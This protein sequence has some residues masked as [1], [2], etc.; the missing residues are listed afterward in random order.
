MEKS[1]L[2]ILLKIYNQKGEFLDR[3]LGRKISDE[4]KKRGVK[5]ISR[6]TRERVLTKHKENTEKLLSN[7]A[8]K[9]QD[10]T[11]QV[12]NIAIEV[13]E[14]YTKQISLKESY[15]NLPHIFQNFVDP[16]ANS[17]A[18]IAQRIE[19]DYQGY[20]L[21]NM[22]ESMIIRSHLNVAYI[23]E[24]NAL[25]TKERIIK[26]DSQA[27]HIYE[28]ACAIF[29]KKENFYLLSRVNK[30]NIIYETLLTIII[31]NEKVNLE[32]KFDE[33]RCIIFGLGGLANAFIGNIFYKR[34]H[35][36]DIKVDYKKEEDLLSVRDTKLYKEIILALE[37]LKEVKIDII[38]AKSQNKT[39]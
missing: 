19:G 35:K 38:E 33:M 17:I 8:I 20:R 6:I 5:E 10:K 3:S 31:N 26:T 29:T 9:V 39:Y 22:G 28:G 25:F 18:L 27:V 36:G 14:K 32:E 4:I 12:F 37:Y 34:K 23:E 11:L 13:Y 7:Q 15:E 2:D 16:K 21:S 24:K 1:K 30:N